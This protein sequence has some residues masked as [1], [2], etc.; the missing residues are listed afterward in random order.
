MAG[1]VSIMIP[2]KPPFLSLSMD[3]DPQALSEI[4]L[5]FKFCAGGDFGMTFEIVFVKGSGFVVVMVS[6]VYLVAE[7]NGW[8][9]DCTK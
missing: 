9:G 6:I 8:I 2:L 1:V 7:V 5:H 3:L 4:S